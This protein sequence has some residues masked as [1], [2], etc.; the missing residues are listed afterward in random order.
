MKARGYRCAVTLED[1]VLEDPDGE[2]VVVPLALPVLGGFIVLMVE[3]TGTFDAAEVQTPVEVSA[4]AADADGEE[5]V[6]EAEALVGE[7]VS[8]SPQLKSNNGK[9]FR[10]FP[11]MP[12]LGFGVSGAA[13]RRVYHHTLT[14]P[15]KE[16]PTSFQY[17]SALSIDATDWPTFLPLTGCPVSVIQTGLP[18][19]ASEV[20]PNAS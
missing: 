20:F 16:Q 11:I 14:L 2:A 13:S 3:D 4:D 9:D 19:P 17:L 10:S 7:C 5:E 18:L 15:N 1:V 12:K 6:A 8:F